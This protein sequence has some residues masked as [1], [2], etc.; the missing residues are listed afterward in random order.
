MPRA[1]FHLLSLA[2]LIPCCWMILSQ[3]LLLIT[4]HTAS[5]YIWGCL[6]VRIG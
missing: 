5:D 2:R 6:V 3:V 4:R 1:R